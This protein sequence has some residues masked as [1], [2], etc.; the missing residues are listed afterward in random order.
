MYTLHAC[1]LSCFSLVQL[2]ATLGT[3]AHQSPLSLEFSRQEYWSGLPCP[4]S[5]DL[6][7]SGIKLVFLMSPALAG[8]FFTTE[9]PGKPIYTLPCAKQITSRK[10]LY[11]TRSSAQCSVMTYRE[12]MEYWGEGGSRGRK[13]MYAAAKSLQSCPNLCD[14][15]V[16][17]PLGSPIPRILQARTLEWV[18]I[19]FSNA[20]K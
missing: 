11:S 9:P 15:I 18:A 7:N 2:F 12:G 5:E 17:S 19:S 16:G 1:V 13:Y 3:V 8:R 6:L 20:R 14:P 4:P 10:V